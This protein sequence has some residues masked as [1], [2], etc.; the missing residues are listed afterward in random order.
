MVGDNKAMQSK[1]MVLTEDREQ[2]RPTSCRISELE[3]RSVKS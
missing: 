3:T 1:I 2:E